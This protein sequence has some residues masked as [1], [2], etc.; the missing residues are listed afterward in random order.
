MGTAHNHGSS[1]CNTCHGGDHGHGHDECETG[2]RAVSRE[3]IDDEH[4]S[5]AT[6][7]GDGEIDADDA[8]VYVYASANAAGVAVPSTLT[9]PEK[10][11]AHRHIHIVAVD[12]VVNVQG[13]GPDG[14]QIRIEAGGSANVFA[15]QPLDADPCAC[16]CPYW[17]ACVCA[18]A[19]VTPVPPAPLTAASRRA[20]A[21]R[22]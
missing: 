21:R 19:T 12:G 14:G 10:A 17:Q 4:L 6:V 20:A 1:D 3:V 13:V 11:P 2:C 9:L 22:R 15:I 16:E 8:I 18:P 5:A 7:C